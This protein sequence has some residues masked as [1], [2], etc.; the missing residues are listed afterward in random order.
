MK[1][2]LIIIAFVLSLIVFMV[3]ARNAN[4]KKSYLKDT[5]IMGVYINNE[6]SEKIPLKDE[7]NFYKAVCDDENVSVSWDI[8]TWGLLLKN[9]TAKTKCNLYFYSGQTVFDF[10]YTGGEQTFTAPISG[11]YKVELWGASG[12]SYDETYHGGNGGYTEGLIKLNKDTSL[13]VYVGATNICKE[14]TEGPT[15]ISFNGGGSADNGDNWP[16]RYFCGGGGATDI[17]IE[18]ANWD[19]FDSLKSRIMAA[20]GGGGASFFDSTYNFAIGGSAGGLISYVGKTGSAT[21]AVLN[22]STQTFGSS[23]GI[24]GSHVTNGGGG[25]YYGGASASWTGGAGGSSFISGHNGCDAIKEESTDGN[26]IHTGQSIHYSNLY[27]TDTVMIDGNGYKWTTEKGEYTGMPSHSNNSTITGNTG[28][29]YARIT[30][31]SID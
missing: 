17:R 6:L 21:L 23:F 24:G 10:D 5:E 18:N 28:N 3:N 8:E 30:L 12:A 31:V 26:I 15:D 7:A 27:F 29:G 2:G 13:Y 20:A 11:T 9:L 1:K 19:N 16:N 14:G 4:L 22:P 25:G